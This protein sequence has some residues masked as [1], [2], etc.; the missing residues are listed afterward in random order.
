[1]SK[2]LGIDASLTATGIC[3]LDINSLNN[4]EIHTE[5][6]ENDLKGIER[7]LFIEKCIETYAKDV[8]LVVMENY[9]YDAKYNR[10]KLA[11]LQGVI[12]RRLY[13]MNKKLILIDT[14]NLKKVLTGESK[15]PTSL[16]TKEWVMQYTKNRYKIDFKGKDDECDAFGLSLIGLFTIVDLE[17]FNIINY[18]KGD[19]KE[20]VDK[21]KSK[22]KSKPKI[23]KNLSYYFNLPYNIIGEKKIDNNEEVYSINIPYL[24][25]SGV[26]STLKKAIKDLEKNRNSKVRELRKNKKRIMCKDTRK[27]SFVQ[28][29]F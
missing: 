5:T 14:S 21:I 29:R 27:V 19:I 20:V 13:L 11:E 1:M 18:I 4:R 15:N 22:E 28:K 16:K 24:D 25:V 9:A 3:V 7:I 10:E 12:K 2:I 6:L 8:D 17:E 26:G 23:K